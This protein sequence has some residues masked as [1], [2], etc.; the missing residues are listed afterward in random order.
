MKGEYDGTSSDEVAGT[1]LSVS[2]EQRDPFSLMM[3]TLI[4]RHG[5]APADLFM[6]GLESQADAIMNYWTLRILVEEHQVS[7]LAP[8]GTDSAGEPVKPLHAA[9]LMN[10]AGA[11][12]ALL[13]LQAYEGGMD[14]R[15]MQLAIR[16]AHQQENLLLAALIMRHA[17]LRG[18][19]GTLMKAL[20]PSAIH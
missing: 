17:E 6:H 19:L 18:E 10:N 13:F 2:D 9:I 3:R 1:L 4:Q 11:L 15:D 5:H 20:S 14:G 8:V 7:P 12:A 16:M